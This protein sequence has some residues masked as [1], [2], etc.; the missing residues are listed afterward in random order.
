[1]RMCVSRIGESTEV[2]LESPHLPARAGALFQYFTTTARAAWSI[3]QSATLD[4]IC[5]WVVERLEAG[6]HPAE[7][8][9]LLS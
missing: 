9:T 4:A 6:T 5:S 7:A 2:V 3:T 1:M 8:I